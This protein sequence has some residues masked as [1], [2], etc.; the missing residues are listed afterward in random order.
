VRSRR[1]AS[2]S[3]EPTEPRYSSPS[4]PGA[5][6]RT[7]PA[8]WERAPPRGSQPPMRTSAAA[9]LRILSQ[10]P[11]SLGTAQQRPAGLPEQ[12]ER[13]VDDR[14]GRD[15]FLRI[16]PAQLPR[17]DQIEASTVSRLTEARERQWLG[18]VSALEDNLR[19]I[20]SRKAQASV[21]S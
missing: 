19:H 13:N 3:P 16:D 20:R 5:P 8:S 2:A 11:L 7:D 15:R 21:S 9:R 10:S 14:D 1:S 6:A 12:V 17:L 4:G 18:E